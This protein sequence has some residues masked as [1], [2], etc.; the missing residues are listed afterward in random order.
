MEAIATRVEPIA[1]RVEAIATRVEPVATRVEA[2]ALGLEAIGLGSA[3]IA[4]RLEAIALR[5]E[6]IA[7]R[8]E[9][10]VLRVEAIATRVELSLLVTR[11]Y[12]LTKITRKRPD[13]SSHAAFSRETVAFFGVARGI[14]PCVPKPSFS[15]LEIKSSSASV[16]IQVRLNPYLPKK[17]T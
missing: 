3:V 16:G 4:L 7:F 13:V 12:I 5:L 6:A 15:I 9:A 10:I 1:T 11:S 14:V 8:L 17:A 2:I